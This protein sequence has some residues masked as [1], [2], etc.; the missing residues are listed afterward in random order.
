MVSLRSPA[1]RPRSFLF[2]VGAVLALT[3]ARPDDA[4][5]GDVGD[6]DD[7]PLITDGRQSRR[8]PRP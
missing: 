1:R 4:G 3:L 8:R 2:I 7:D 6:D 5:A